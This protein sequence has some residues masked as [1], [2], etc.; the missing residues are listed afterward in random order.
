MAVRQGKILVIDDNEDIL[1]TLKMIAPPAG[2]KHYDLCRPERDQP[3]GV[4]DEI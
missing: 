2:R 1:F 4:E 3:S